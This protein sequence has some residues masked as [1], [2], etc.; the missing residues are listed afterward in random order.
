MAASSNKRSQPSTT[1]G[2]KNHFT[3]II[4][5][6]FPR[7]DFIDPP[8][9]EWDSS[10]DRT[11]WKIL[12]GATKGS[13]IDW[14]AMADRF[15]VTLPFLLQQAAWLYERQLSQ[16][17]AQLRKVNKTASNASS[18][19]PG[20]IANSGTAGG[21]AMK[22][23]G[24]GGSRVPSSQSVRPRENPNAKSEGSA[25]STPL[26]G[27]AVP[28]PIVSRTSSTNTVYQTRLIPAT[29]RDTDSQH[30]SDRRIVKS[31]KKPQPQPAIGSRRL[32]HHGQKPNPLPTK[33]PSSPSSSCSSSSDSPAPLSRS[34]AFARRP[35]F[36]APKPHLGPLSDADDD[37]DDTASFLPF[38]SANQTIA[39]QFDPG[40]TLRQ[41]TM[42]GPAAQIPPVQRRQS[43]V[44]KPKPPAPQSQSSSSP[45]SS[46]NSAA[47]FGAAPFRPSAQS[48]SN[49]STN[50]QNTSPNPLHALSPR[51]RRLA[52]EGKE[53]DG[54][55]SMGSSFSDLED[56]SVTQSALE[57][58]LAREMRQGGSQNVASRMSS[59]SQALKSRY[60]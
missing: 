21:Y 8:P 20:S 22:R 51:Q 49:V 36:S 41:T 2:S 40:A 9:L 23:G 6:P 32:S 16:V 25:P 54:T 38:S 27:K 45:S 12:S 50:Q 53:S 35:R 60:L 57:E 1:N 48:S 59:I 46:T 39:P 18:P 47:P 5:C 26:Q 19:T 7:G 10:K 34:R 33:V 3:M 14:N 43:Q 58:A 31:E 4:K 30:K 13:D 55:P 11:L 44:Q 17:R 37:E 56:A 24:S 28:A 52:R 42:T 15:N 29:P